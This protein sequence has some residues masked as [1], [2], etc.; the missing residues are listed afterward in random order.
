MPITVK[1]SYAEDETL[2]FEYIYQFP[3]LIM[4]DR[5]VAEKIIINF[6]ERKELHDNSADALY[7]DAQS[8]NHK[9]SSFVPYAYRMQYNPTRIDQGVLSMY[10]KRER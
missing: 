2:I 9:V 3:H 4:P 10:G 7:L 5:D 6:L 1:S 8:A